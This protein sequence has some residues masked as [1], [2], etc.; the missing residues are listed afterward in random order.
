[1]SY[2]TAVVAPHFVS[3]V[4]DKRHTSHDGKFADDFTKVIRLSENKV[5]A[6]TGHADFVKIFLEHFPIGFEY[7]SELLINDIKSLV[8]EGITGLK[9]NM[10]GDIKLAIT[11]TGVS[12]DKKI[13]LYSIINNPDSPG[14]KITELHYELKRTDSPVFFSMDPDDIELNSS[15]SFHSLMRHN[16]LKNEKDAVKIQKQLQKMVA[17]ASNSVSF[18]SDVEI[19][20]I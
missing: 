8:S 20:K 11:V 6:F 14:E 10:G 3:V 5:L 4:G 9:D 13:F 15:Q 16:K 2:V 12:D 19:V 1:M 18:N 7:S 17:Q